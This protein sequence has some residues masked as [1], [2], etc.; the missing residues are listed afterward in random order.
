MAARRSRSLCLSAFCC[1]SAAGLALIASAGHVT[2]AIALANAPSQPLMYT[3]YY[4]HD[5]KTTQA[6]TTST[7][8]R[9]T[10]RRRSTATSRAR[11]RSSTVRQWARRCAF[12][13]TTAC[14]EW[15]RCAGRGRGEGESKATRAAGGGSGAAGQGV[16]PRTSTDEACNANQTE[17]CNQSQSQHNSNTIKAT[18]LRRRTTARS[19]S[20][21]TR[22]SAP[23]A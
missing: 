12:T 2:V 16:P 8:S 23:A 14:I 15:R 22:R 18:S 6:S 4:T 1:L 10:A 20:A 19:S 7:C 21:S 5:Q 13:M 17:C 3:L 9:S 11:T